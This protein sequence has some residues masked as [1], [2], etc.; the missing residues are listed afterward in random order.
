MSVLISDTDCELWYDRAEELGVDYIRMPYQI[1]GKEYFYDL[2]K[3]T[4]INEFYRLVRSGKMPST[5]ALNVQDYIDFIE[6]YFKRGED[7]FYVS[8]S[9][10]MSGTFNQLDKAIEQLKQT[11]PER[12]ITVFD[13]RCISVSAGLMVE[14]AAKL[15]KQGLSD[16]ELY[17]KLLEYRDK[18]GTYFIVDNLFHLKRGG[19]LSAIAAFAGTAL[20]IKPM[21]TYN[22]EGGLT[23]LQKPKG[24]KKSISIMT[25]YAINE[26]IEV[27]Q[28]R[29]YVLDADCKEEGDKIKDVILESYPNADVH[30]LPIGPVIGAH[31][32][33]GTLA[34]I[35][36]A[37]QRAIP[38]KKGI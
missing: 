19:R 22:D 3:E 32:G 38:L 17:E 10:A 5:S 11:Y 14:E 2:G 15:K 25:Q 1:D 28:H 34:I 26:M 23:V 30:R 18:I 37:K 7:L 9:H 8:F 4:D 33:P 20:G 36:T 16:E 12:K 24:R 6:P 13:T 29:I 27:D 35:F 31:A 21:L